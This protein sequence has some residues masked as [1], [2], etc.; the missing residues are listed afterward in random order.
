[1]FSG[2]RTEAP[3]E[4]ATCP[5][6]PGFVHR[7]GA[8]SRAC[9][10]ALP[11][12]G[13]GLQGAKRGSTGGLAHSEVIRSHTHTHPHTGTH[14]HTSSERTEGSPS[15]PTVHPVVTILGGPQARTEEPWGGC[16]QTGGTKR[17]ESHTIDI[18]RTGTQSS[19]K[20]TKHRPQTASPE[21][22]VMRG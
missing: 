11:Q 15:R 1:M 22:S 16:V 20:K 7:A 3:R 10:R 2:G 13:G 5:Q 4:E 19:E 8:D 21:A 17:K 14:T 9:D 18:S 6:N 12:K